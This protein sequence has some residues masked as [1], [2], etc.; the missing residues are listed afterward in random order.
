VL[1]HHS[2]QYWW[3]GASGNA[4]ISINVVPVRWTQLVL[5]CVTVCGQ[6][7]HLSI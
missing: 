1:L 3:F 5:A 6:V 7:N 4:L 2:N